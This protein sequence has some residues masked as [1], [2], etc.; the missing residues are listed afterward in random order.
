MADPIAEDYVVSRT[1]HVSSTRRMFSKKTKTKHSRR[2]A[3]A[4]ES[5]GVILVR[6]FR[7]EIGTNFGRCDV[8]FRRFGAAEPSESR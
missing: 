1:R 5:D 3:A 4:L 6:D 7:V 8:P 2:T